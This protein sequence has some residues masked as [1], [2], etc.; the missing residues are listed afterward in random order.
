MLYCESQGYTGASLDGGT[1]N[2]WHCDD[3]SGNKV[4]IDPGA[5]CQ[6][7]DGTNVAK[8][9]NF[10]DPY[11]WGCFG[12]LSAST[13]SIWTADT[14]GNFQQNFHIGDQVRLYAR[15]PQQTCVWVYEVKPDGSKGYIYRNSCNPA[16]T[17]YWSGSYGQPAGWRHYFLQW[18]SSSGWQS[19]DAWA[20][21]G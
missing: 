14:S 4:G 15:L 8:W 17:I 21:A 20:Y 10:N 5:A 11:S 2:D 13:F 16:G 9:D 6:W 12:T 18:Q 7:Q 19:V 1:I 3:A